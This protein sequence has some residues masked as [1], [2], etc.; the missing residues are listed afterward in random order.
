MEQRAFLIAIGFLSGIGV[1]LQVVMIVAFVRSHC[2]FLE[3]IKEK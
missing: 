1:T 3:S 2:A